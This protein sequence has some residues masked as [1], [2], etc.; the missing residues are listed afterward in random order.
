MKNLFTI[1]IRR[2]LRNLFSREKII[3]MLHDV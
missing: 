1:P 2:D 3:L